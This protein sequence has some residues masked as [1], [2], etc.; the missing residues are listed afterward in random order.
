M[1]LKYSASFDLH[2]KLKDNKAASPNDVQ[3]CAVEAPPASVATKQV[4]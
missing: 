4:P 3:H 1:V 2:T